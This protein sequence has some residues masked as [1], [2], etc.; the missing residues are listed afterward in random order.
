M[1]LQKM[2]SFCTVYECGNISKAAEKL[3]CTQPALSKQMANIENELGYPLFDRHGKKL[4]IN[5]NG[6]I[7]YRFARN[8]INDYTLLKRELYLKNNEVEHEVRLG[9]TNF[10]GTFLL[11]SILG[12]FKKDY[13]VTPVNFMIDYLP[14][15][16]E[17]LDK[18]VIHFAIIPETPSLNLQSNLV[19]D[20]I[21]EDEFVLVFPTNHPLAY[22]EDI[23]AKDIINYPFL[24]SQESS[25]TRKFVT[26]AL[27]SNNIILNNIIDMSNIYTITQAIIDGLGIS[28]FSK[29]AVKNYEKFGML[30][31]ARLKDLTLKRQL[32][33]VYKSKHTF[34]EDEARFMK[35]FI[36]NV[37]NEDNEH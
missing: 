2:I 37:L 9:T 13:P 23:Y 1:E 17:S 24:I 25:A 30:K 26:D 27:K 12:K 31:Y 11:P 18:D 15:I 28:I 7:F 35:Y 21:V 5:E 29:N 3:Y 6:M 16:L 34:L 8:V 20:P 14:K 33:F 10:I 32:Y 36:E 22:K 4:S 19:L